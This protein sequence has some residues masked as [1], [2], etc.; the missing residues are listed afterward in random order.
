M[1]HLQN[2][3]PH[4]IPQSILVSATSS[5]KGTL[6]SLDTRIWKLMLNLK[7]IIFVKIILVSSLALRFIMPTNLLPTLDL[8][9]IMENPIVIYPGNQIPNSLR[10]SNVTQ[11]NLL[12]A[13]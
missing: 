13:F 9:E 11:N 3:I 6:S 1:C 8:P 7:L 2:I 10:A 4:R 12:N 5:K